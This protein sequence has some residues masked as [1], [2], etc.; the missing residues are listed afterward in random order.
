MKYYKG[1]LKQQTTAVYNNS[2]KGRSQT[3][4]KQTN[5]YCMSSFK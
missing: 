1:T 2:I 3:S 4:N 5:T